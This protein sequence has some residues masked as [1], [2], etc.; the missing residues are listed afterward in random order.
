MEY[1]YELGGKDLILVKNSE[2][3]D[4]IDFAYSENQSE[5]YSYLNL[6]YENKKINERKVRTTMSD[7][8]SDDV[9]DIHAA[10]AASSSSSSSR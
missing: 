10:P 4:A 5:A 3:L 1:F 2:G 9:G 7:N 6:E 8:D